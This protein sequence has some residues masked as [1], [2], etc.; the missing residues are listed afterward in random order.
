MLFLMACAIAALLR[1]KL[2]APRKT[3]VE[4]DPGGESI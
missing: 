2:T 3:H 1:Y 4:A